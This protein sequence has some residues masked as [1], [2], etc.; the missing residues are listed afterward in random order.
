[1]TQTETTIAGMTAT[2]LAAAL[3][4]EVRAKDIAGCFATCRREPVVTVEME[5]DT[6][7]G[8]SATVTIDLVAQ[9]WSDE[10]GTTPLADLWEG[11]PQTVDTLLSEILS[12]WYSLET[13]W[14]D[15]EEE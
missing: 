11:R 14:A 6:K 15:G 8:G 13:Q 9:T 7:D 10:G 4:A 5:L 3:D 12:H 2:E 1:M